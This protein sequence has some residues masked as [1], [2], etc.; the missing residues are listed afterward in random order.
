MRNKL[1]RARGG[2]YPPHPH[3]AKLFYQE[4]N[5]KK[6]C[7]LELA[8]NDL[9]DA[10]SGHLM[11]GG[12]LHALLS[13]VVNIRLFYLKPTKNAFYNPTLPCRVAVV[14]YNYLLGKKI[15]NIKGGLL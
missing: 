13:F 10:K 9:E 11:V 7:Y 15:G 14:G 1:L 2:G 3:F 4:K 5:Q 8:G 12:E 6:S